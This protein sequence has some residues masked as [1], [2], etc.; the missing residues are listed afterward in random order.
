[1][2]EPILKVIGLAIILQ[3]FTDIAVI[4]IEK[5][6]RF[7]KYFAY[8]FLGTITDV[9]V[10][11]T[12]T[13][14]LRCVWALIFGLLVGNLV[15]CIISYVTDPY[16]PKFQFNKGRT[17]ELFGFEEWILDSS[18]LTFL[19]THGDDILWENYSL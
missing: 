14:L 19:I 15:R 11:I 16:R 2:A 4:Y 5:E 18:I 1:M 9:T 6:L 7:H 12:A 10:T 17:K 13:F 3:S 8:R